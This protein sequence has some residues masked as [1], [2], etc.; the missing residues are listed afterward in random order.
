MTG[1][2]VLMFTLVIAAVVV[3]N[4]EKA[5]AWPLLFIGYIMMRFLEAFR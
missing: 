1:M 2:D 5:L 4:G 3:T